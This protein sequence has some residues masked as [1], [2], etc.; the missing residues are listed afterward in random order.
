MKY[1][2]E[3]DYYDLYTDLADLK[4]V[5]TANETSLTE[6]AK[7]SDVKIKAFRIRLQR[8]LWRISDYDSEHDNLLANVRSQC[9]YVT[10]WTEVKKFKKEWV[11]TIDFYL[12]KQPSDYTD[13]K[14]SNAA[15]DLLNALIALL[16]VY[17]AGSK[18]PS[19]DRDAA[20]NKAITAYEKATGKKW[21]FMDSAHVKDQMLQNQF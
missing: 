17:P 14:I 9:E 21:S 7:L 20:V 12:D 11:E 10:S 2:T 19:K 8:S 3:R 6:L 4:M 13:Q 16:L 18:E 1:I 15:P 5:L